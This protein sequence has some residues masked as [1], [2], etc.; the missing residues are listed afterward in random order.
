VY[1]GIHR[2]SRRGAGV[3][4]GGHRAYVP[5]DDLRW[6]DRHALMRHGR[7]LVRQFETETDRALCLIIDASASMAYR[8]ERAPAA[9]LAFSLLIAAALARV[10]LAGGDPVSID[11]FAGRHTRRLKTTGGGE[12]FERV[13]SVL[14]SV[15]PGGDAK[16]ELPAIERALAPVARHAG[17]GSVIVLLSDLLDLSAG[18]LDRVSTLATNGRTVLALRILD[19]VEATFPFEGPVR[20]RALEQPHIVE[21]NAD[22]AREGYLRALENIAL[23]WNRRLLGRGGRL[24]RATT[25]EDP[26][27]VLRRLLLAARGTFR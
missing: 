17:R 7:L 12:A 11:W 1:A 18:T 27:D 26:V 8:S 9:K 5:G 2:S 14:E 25:D 21:T 16:L 19:P 6:L 4:F 20:L 10:A 22:S 15:Q 13:L 3:E 24:V 23:E